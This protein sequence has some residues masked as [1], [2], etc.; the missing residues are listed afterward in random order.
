MRRFLALAFI[1]VVSTAQMFPIPGPGRASFGGGATG[2]WGNT[3]ANIGSGV[4]IDNTGTTVAITSTTQT[5]EVNNL[6]VCGISTNE[7]TTD[8]ADGSGYNQISGVTNSGTALTWTKAYEWC[9]MNSA[10]IGNGICTAIYY[11]DVTT[12]LSSS[13]SITAT[14]ANTSGTKD[15]GIICREFTQTG[16]AVAETAGDNGQSVDG[17]NLG[18][19]EV[20]TGVAS[21]NHLFVRAYAGMSNKFGGSGDA[22]YDMWGLN[23]VRGTNM[24]LRVESRIATETTSDSHTPVEFIGTDHASSMVGFYTQ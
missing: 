14:I 19:Q 1:L 17:G 20:V 15:T 13:S 5:V 6:I 7:D 21:R 2:T 4:S 11:T 22:N 12:Q 8:T 23:D 16:T 9:N 24:T 18:A 10:T 3:E